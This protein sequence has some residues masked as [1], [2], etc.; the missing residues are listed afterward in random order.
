[1]P[2]NISVVDIKPKTPGVSF[3]GTSVKSGK[4][5]T[6][7]NLYLKQQLYYFGISLGECPTNSLITDSKPTN[8]SVVNL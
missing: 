3:R 7:H 1:M 5:Y 2:K 8:Y 4:L 6:S